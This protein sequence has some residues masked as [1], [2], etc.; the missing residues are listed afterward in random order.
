VVYIMNIGVQEGKITRVDECLN[1]N[2]SLLSDK[3]T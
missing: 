3:K 2:L 1:N